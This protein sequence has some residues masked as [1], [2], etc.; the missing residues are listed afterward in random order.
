MHKHPLGAYRHGDPV[1]RH[2]RGRPGHAHR[3][4]SHGP[5]GN[6]GRNRNGCGISGV[7]RRPLRH[8]NFFLDRRRVE[9]PLG[10]IARA[11]LYRE[12]IDFRSPRHGGCL[13]WAARPRASQPA[14]PPLCFID[15]FWGSRAR[16]IS[17]WAVEGGSAILE[18]QL[19]VLGANLLRSVAQHRVRAK[20]LPSKDTA[21]VK[22]LL[23]PV[24]ERDGF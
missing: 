13:R 14:R 8:Q 15:S 3:L 22:H 5:A 11:Q 6:R 9:E 24:L 2:G 10:A 23:K 21:S 18:K 17:P 20:L 16:S 1:D 19:C 7:G 4:A 12:S